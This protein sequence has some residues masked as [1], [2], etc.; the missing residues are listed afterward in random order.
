M[1]NHKLFDI[2]VEEKPIEELVVNEDLTERAKRKMLNDI[3]FLREYGI[4]PDDYPGIDTMDAIDQKTAKMSVSYP[5]YDY[6]IHRENPADT[7]KWLEAARQIYYLTHT[8]EDRGKALQKV[9]A[10]WNH[11]EQRAF[12]YWLRFYEEGVQLKYKAGELSMNPKTAQM[13]L[14][15]LNDTSQLAYQMP[16]PI[17]PPSFE[18]IK[19]PTTHPDMIEDECRE[20]IEAIRTKVI[21]RL[22]SVEKL[23]R[24]DDCH[25]LVGKE[26]EAFFDAIHHL[27]KKFYT[28][29]KRSLSTR[30]YE[31]MIVREANILIMQATILLHHPIQQGKHH[32]QVQLAHQ[33]HCRWILQPQV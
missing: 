12:F 30:L 13:P 15:F 26:L 19:N 9:V 17:Q 32:P 3:K 33:P 27:K 24:S 16:K 31:D 25:T 11:M 4:K 2:E 10:N 7:R 29:N 22:D 18:T 1:P 21:S 5:N 20:K 8:G 6:N 23:L 14:Q 28:V